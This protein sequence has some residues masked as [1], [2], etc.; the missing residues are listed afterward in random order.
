MRIRPMSALALGLVLAASAISACDSGP[1]HPRV[2]CDY[3]MDAGTFVG[4]VV[5]VRG[6]EAT[7]RVESAQ[8]KRAADASVLHRLQKGRLAVVHY[9]AH[10]ERF[11]RVGERYKVKVWPI[12]GFLSSV[13]TPDRPC[14]GGTVHA[15]GAPIDT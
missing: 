10:E 14:S 12:A 6:A 11:L 1:G 4:R 13:H 2:M 7:F 3:A 8:P 15:D 9:E 5:S